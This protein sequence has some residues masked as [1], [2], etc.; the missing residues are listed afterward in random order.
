MPEK[1]IHIIGI[2]SGGTFTDFIYY[3]GSKLYSHKILSTPKQPEAAIINGLQQLRTMHGL[4]LEDCDIIHGSTVAT[5]AVLENK[6]A[7]TA[8]VTNRGFADMLTIGRQARDELYALEPKAPPIP[9]ARDLCFEVNARIDASGNIIS[10]FSSDDLEHLEKAIA[11]ADVEAVA[12]NLLFSFIDNSDEKKIAA[13]LPKHLF[14]T[15]SADVLAEYKEYERGISTWLNACVGPVIKRYLSKLSRSVNA[16]SIS[17]MKSS[18]GT[19]AIDHCADNG[20]QL[21]LSGPAGGLIAARYIAQQCHHDKVL[22]LDMGGTS[23]DVALIDG[24]LQLTTEGRIGPYPLAIASADIHTIGAG[25]GSIAWIDTGG[26]L[27]VGPQSAGADPGPACY[28]KGGMRATIT[29][30]NLV[31]G[32][33]PRSLQLASGLKLDFDAAFNSIKNLA[34]AL[35]LSIEDTAAGIISIAEEHMSN[36][37]RKISIQRGHDPRQFVLASFGGAGGLHICA[38][39][40]ALQMH[41]AIIPNHAGVLSAFGMLV[42]SKKIELSRTLRHSN[43]LDE[44][45]I[46]LAFNKL[47]EHASNELYQQ[48]VAKHDIKISYSVDM[49][50]IGQSFTLNIDWL[51]LVRSEKLF[52]E[53][54]KQQY[55]HELENGVELVTIRV[56][57]SG[58]TR[59]LNLIRTKAGNKTSNPCDESNVYNIDAPVPIY[60]RHQLGSKHN[61]L[62]PAIIAEQ[63]TTSY[64]A[65]NWQAQLDEYGNIHLSKM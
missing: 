27:Q 56:S 15:C 18:G 48:G 10:A 29:D 6:G 39:A 49:R 54:H 47:A 2:D 44:N 23:T 36:A 34:T 41:Q 45:Q 42:A 32:R 55:G 17:I 1:N 26:V 7:R 30:A 51:G 21:L 52:S 62:G 65:P 22:S 24:D 46:E 11:A 63:V 53:K 4:E 12:I 16:N 25:G 64:I 20:A 60:Q 40:D 59:Q 58:P 61:I 3:D 35:G 38:L 33:L 9:V 8:F 50:Y 13:S 57:A 28:G 37:L 14:I 5:N 31:L 43:K 19:A